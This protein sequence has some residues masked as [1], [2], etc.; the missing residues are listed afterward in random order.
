MSDRNSFYRPDMK[1]HVMDAC[2][3]TYPREHFDMILD[4]STI[5]SVLCGKACFYNTALML[6]EC[7]RVLKTG[8]Y[9]VTISYGEPEARLY[10]LQS[11]HLS[12]DIQKFK[13]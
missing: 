8:G 6:K 13:I 7:Q 12:F 9:Y 11:P 2:N 3:M 10:H 4:K 1:F 5:D